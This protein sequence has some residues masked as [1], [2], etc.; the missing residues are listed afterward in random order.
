MT[1]IN[2]IIKDE[3]MK[4]LKDSFSLLQYINEHSI[5]LHLFIF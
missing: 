1:D 4:R 3:K 2:I 5:E